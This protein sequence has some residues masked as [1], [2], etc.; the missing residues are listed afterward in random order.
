[1]TSP[2]AAG[3]PVDS[4]TS[5]FKHTCLNCCVRFADA[6][7]W[8]EHYKSDW[9]RY[10][11]KRSLAELAPLTAEAFAA[12]VH[13]LQAAAAGTPKET[14]YCQQ[15]RKQFRTGNA[16]DNHLSSRAHRDAVERFEV[17]AAAAEQ[18]ADQWEEVDRMA[19]EKREK[20][21]S[22]P[23]I[24][25]VDE[26][27]FEELDSDD[28]PDDDDE[29]IEEV[30]SDEWEDDDGDDDDD[31]SSTADR[32]DVTSYENPIK[33]NKCLFCGVR[34]A[35]LV[36]TLKHMSAV[37]SF[38]VPDTEYVVNMPGL[39]MYL[40]KKV[41]RDFICL[42]CNDRG[43][44]FWSLD[45]CRKHMRDKGH[46]K[47]LHEGLALAEYATYYDYSASYPDNVSIHL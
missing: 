36:D 13:S 22:R 47:M 15:C 46:C 12:R 17:H 30:D 44:S 4:A 39:L 6:A 20:E 2:T 43:R 34:S 35:S 7:M 38:F 41:A 29:D 18:V 42:W 33:H 11:L 1:M 37:H 9:H 28:L 32:E 45:A 25:P 21:N 23:A 8:R 14:Q 31:A 26:K 40:G 27:M 19:E 5:T 16:Y 3:A 24:D 10:N